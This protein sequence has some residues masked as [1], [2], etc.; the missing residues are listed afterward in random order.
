[1]P[2]ARRRSW[3]IL[4]S[5]LCCHTSSLFPS[6]SLPSSLLLAHLF[7]IL[8]FSLISLFSPSHFLLIFLCVLP[9]NSFL[10]PR[11]LFFTSHPF[12]LSLYL[13]YSSYSLSLLVPSFSLAF[14]FS[15]FVLF[16]AFP[17]YFLSILPL[18][19]FLHF[20]NSHLLK[21]PISLSLSLPSLLFYPSLSSNFNILSLILFQF[22]S[23]SFLFSSLVFLC[24]FVSFFFLS[25]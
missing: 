10:F 12:F 13:Y 3:K 7:N 1:M 21:G 8:P 24:F 9:R 19:V 23:F 4:S 17:S 6:R 16:L 11:T 25:R 22:L 18:G 14:N 15:L 2:C 20:S 5:R